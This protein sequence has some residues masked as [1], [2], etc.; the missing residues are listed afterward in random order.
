[1]ID[2]SGNL[3]KVFISY[4]HEDKKWLDRLWVHLKPL[5]RDGAFDVWADTRIKVGQSWRSEIQEAIKSANVAVLLISEHFLASDFIAQDELSPLLQAATSQRV[6]ILSVILRPCRF[7]QTKG[8]C[9]LKTVNDPRNPLLQ[10]PE[11]EWTAVLR[12]LANE[13]SAAPTRPIT[14]FRE[15]LHRELQRFEGEIKQKCEKIDSD[16]GL[17]REDKEF[18]KGMWRLAALDRMRESVLDKIIKI[19][20]TEARRASGEIS[21]LTESEQAVP[22]WHRSVLYEELKN[23][24]RRRDMLASFQ[25]MPGWEW[26][27]NENFSPSA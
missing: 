25:K 15:K 26:P 2:E 19:D 18:L 17:V 5:A 9:D 16:P 6:T 22:E 11:A 12:D 1:M 21:P 23:L 4:A 13:I 14:E 20:R 10:M 7:E 24:N 27:P 3:G 8:L